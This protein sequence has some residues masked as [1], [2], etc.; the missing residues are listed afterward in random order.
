MSKGI[1]HRGTYLADLM[2]WHA[3]HLHP[4]GGSNNAV[5]AESTCRAVVT[6][7]TLLD[8]GVVLYCTPHPNPSQ[9]SARYEGLKYQSGVAQGIN[10][11]AACSF[12]IGRCCQ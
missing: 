2:L 7:T 3:F 8:S 5:H 1:T 11:L 9:I 4:V 6:E 12:M 10:S